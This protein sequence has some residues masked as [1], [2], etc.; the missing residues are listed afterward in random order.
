M[1]SLGLSRPLFATEEVVFHPFVLS[2]LYIISDVS[3]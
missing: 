1:T 3:E 2:L